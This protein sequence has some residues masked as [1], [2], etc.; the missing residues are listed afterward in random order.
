MHDL[1][2]FDCDG[3]LVDSELL[4]NQVMIDN[5]ARYGLKLTL[6]DSFGFF[7]G[8]TMTGV[9]DKARSLGADLP[10]DWTEEIY[11]E[12]YEVLKAG[13]PLVSGVRELLAK[14]DANGIPFCVASNGRPEKMQITLGQ[15]GLWERF[16]DVMFS[17]HV[18]GVAKPDPTLFLTA[19]QFFGAQSPVVVEDSASGVTAAIRANMRCLGY[20]AHDDGAGLSALGAEVFSDMSHVPGLLGL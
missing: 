1:V 8:G 17:A 7:V 2:I 18:L 20:A 10:E 4:S 6:E 13:T 12:I 3:V 9:R 11:E 19:S 15:N 5:L 14:L 16:K